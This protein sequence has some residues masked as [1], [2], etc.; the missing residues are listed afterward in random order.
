MVRSSRRQIRAELQ[1]DMSPP[2]EQVSYLLQVLEEAFAVQKAVSNGT[3]AG[4]ASY[5]Q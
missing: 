2:M 5:P 4:P 1:T 3:C